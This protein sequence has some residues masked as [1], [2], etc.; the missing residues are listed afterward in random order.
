[1]AAGNDDHAALHHQALNTQDASQ[2]PSTL[3]LAVLRA[4]ASHDCVRASLAAVFAVLQGPDPGLL[5]PTQERLLAFAKEAAQGNAVLMQ[6]IDG[7]FRPV[8]VEANGRVVTAEQ[9]ARSVE[10][11]PSASPGVLT[12]CLTVY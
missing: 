12:L 8:V 1:M 9:A 7:L 10:P 11:T 5:D 2:P 4:L 3:R 6:W